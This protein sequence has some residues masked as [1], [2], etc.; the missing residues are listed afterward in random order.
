MLVV[1]TAIFVLF[2]R[3]WGNSNSELLLG[4][5]N[6][7]EIIPDAIKSNPIDRSGVISNLKAT[8]VDSTI[9]TREPILMKP[10]DAA[11]TFDKT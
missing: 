11:S 3:N 10:C 6:T 2:R 8:A 5:P 1:I 7:Y 9:A 4:L